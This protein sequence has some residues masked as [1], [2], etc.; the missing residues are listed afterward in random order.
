MLTLL[1]LVTLLSVALPNPLA[2]RHVPPLYQSKSGIL[3]LNGKLSAAPLLFFTLLKTTPIKCAPSPSLG[4]F[5][6]VAGQIGRIAGETGGITKGGSTA[7]S[8]AREANALSKGLSKTSTVSHAGS[9]LFHP[10]N[11]KPLTRSKSLP[12]TKP[13][14]SLPPLKTTTHTQEP[15]SFVPGVLPKHEEPKPFTPKKAGEAPKPSDSLKEPPHTTPTHD[16]PLPFKD[17]PKPLSAYPFHVQRMERLR[18]RIADK[19]LVHISKYGNEEIQE[20]GKKSQFVQAATK[21]A[22]Q[23]TFVGHYLSKVVVPKWR[24]EFPKPAPG[25]LSKTEKMSKAW[26]NMFG[27]QKGV[28][29]AI[30]RVISLPFWP[31]AFLGKQITKLREAAVPHFLK[32]LR[33]HASD[34]IRKDIPHFKF[35]DEVKPSSKVHP[36]PAH[37]HTTGNPSHPGGESDLP[38]V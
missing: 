16:A 2:A 15:N 31:L 24:E 3:G 13:G 10:G 9:D 30:E 5:G 25:Q 20:W 7:S 28:R 35:E 1:S 12:A 4:S 36:D 23:E 27:K 32:W 6:E 17:T 33:A 18:Q 38:P 29:H 22:E 11:G 21:R 19:M 34:P 26:K 8:A 14:N 37:P